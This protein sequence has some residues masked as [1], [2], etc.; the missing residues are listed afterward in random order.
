[1][2]VTSRDIEYRYDGQRYI[3]ELSVDDAMDGKRPGVLVC[4]EGGGISDHAKNV[5]RRLAGLGYTAFAL[6]YLG[7]GKA[8]AQDE[9]MT[10]FRVLLDDPLRARAVGT[11]GL[12]VLL[13]DPHTDTSRVAA[14]GFC[15]G[16]T[17]AIE[18]ARGG[19]D[20]RA[21]VGFHSRLET[22]RPEDA[23]NITGK[24][25][26]NIGADDPLIPAEQ[27]LAFEEEMRAGGVD[28]QLNVY[29]GA[30]HSFTNPGSDGSNPA[31]K[32]DEAATRRSW[33]AMMGLFGEVF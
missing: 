8:P 2:T 18:L 29:G 15:F 14:I 20:L 19:A 24:I 7:D 27:R 22:K 16:G 31:F 12:D 23:V 25:L 33:D 30:V 26:A 3:G 13:A 11:A 1:M 5:A 4:H 21:A 9:I 28:W 10:K 6:D 17:L 32:Y